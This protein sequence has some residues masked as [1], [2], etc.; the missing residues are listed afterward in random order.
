MISLTINKKRIDILF[1]DGYE[2]WDGI[3]IHTAHRD[4]DGSYAG[5]RQALVDEALKR[6][7]KLLN[8]KVL[9]CNLEFSVSPYELK[10]K[11]KLMKFPS[12]WKG[13]FW[14]CL[15][16]ISDKIIKQTKLKLDKKDD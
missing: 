2:I 6:K 10:R 16:P 1:N 11:S 14:M 5:I 12:K 7:V 13:F 4:K 15:Y 3:E 9:D 8:I